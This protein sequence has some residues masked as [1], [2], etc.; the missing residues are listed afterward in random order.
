MDFITDLPRSNNCTELWVV[1]DR[2]TKMAH[3]IA[4]EGDKKTVADLAGIFAQEIWRL[5]GLPC[6]I[7]S[8]RDSRLTSNTWKDFLTITGIR[9]RMSTTFH[10][11]TNGQT[12]RVN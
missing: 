12:E 7:V 4:L 9:P 2:L 3:F 11:Q 5:H 6:D 8:N 10:P 1:I